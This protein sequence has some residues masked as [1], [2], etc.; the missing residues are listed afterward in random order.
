MFPSPTQDYQKPFG[1]YSILQHV[2]PKDPTDFAK[3]YV[4]ES[5]VPAICRTC[6]WVTNS[7]IDAVDD[8]CNSC[9]DDRGV[10]SVFSCMEEEG[11]DVHI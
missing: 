8:P 1:W 2:G 3:K 5:I 10:R 11:I 6:G 4:G 9:S 7:E